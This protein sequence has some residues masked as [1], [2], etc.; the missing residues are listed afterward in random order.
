DADH[1]PGVRGHGVLLLD[2]YREMP[3][4]GVLRDGGRAQLDARRA[5]GGE[6]VAAL[7]QAQPAQT[8]QRDG[9]GEHHDGARQ[10]EGAQP[11]LP[12]RALRVAERARACAGLLARDARKEASKGPVQ[13]AQRLLRRATWRPRTARAQ[14]SA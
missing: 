2:L 6:V 5:P 12:A 10:P 11:A 3:V 9:L 14:P 4:L 13:V 1:R 7:L 8:G